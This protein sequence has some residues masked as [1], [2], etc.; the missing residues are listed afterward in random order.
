MN[1]EKLIEHNTEMDGIVINLSNTPIVFILHHN[2]LLDG[3]RFED[4]GQ[5]K[6][7]RDD[8][9]VHVKINF[10]KKNYL[11]DTHFGHY[12]YEI[13][14]LS[15]YSIQGDGPKVSIMKVIKDGEFEGI[16]KSALNL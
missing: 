4:R 10:I 3:I 15:T 7:L 9:F 2:K 13:L 12:D 6:S 8:Q 16:I 11:V 14:P 1:I 5:F